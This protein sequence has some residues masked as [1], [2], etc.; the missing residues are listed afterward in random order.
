MAVS[1]NKRKNN[2]N[3][4]KKCDYI[5]IRPLKQR[6]ELNR[7]PPKMAG[8]RL[9]GYILQACAERMERDGLPIDQP[10]ADEEK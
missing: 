4:N 9:Q 1:E 3:Y 6:A 10:A 2:D 7:K 5:S 8:Q